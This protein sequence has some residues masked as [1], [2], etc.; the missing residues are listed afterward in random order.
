MLINYHNK[1]FRPVQNSDNGEVGAELIFH[2]QQTGQIVT[3]TYSGGVIVVGHLIAL[4]DEQGHLDMR[5]HQVNEQGQ[6][7]T[8]ICHSKPVLLPN[9]KIQLLE[10]WRWTSGDGS[11]GTSVLEEL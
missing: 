3:C 5:Y 4:V 1:K 11:T 2:Y 6:L 7:R 9:G 10:T 8:G